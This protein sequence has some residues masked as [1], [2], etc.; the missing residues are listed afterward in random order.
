MQARGPYRE[1]SLSA[2]LAQG[3]TEWRAVH[4]GCGVCVH[5]G[6]WAGWMTDGVKPATRM[7]GGN[8]YCTLRDR[9]EGSPQT[10]CGSWKRALRR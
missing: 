5:F 1:A 2:A 10:G 8:A 7:I 4:S 3:S 9:V 6:H